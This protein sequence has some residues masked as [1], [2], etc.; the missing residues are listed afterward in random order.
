ML[1]RSMLTISQG[2][3][4]E[5]ILQPTECPTAALSAPRWSPTSTWRSCLSQRSTGSPTQ[6]RS[7]HSCAQCWVRGS[8]SAYVFQLTGGVVSWCSRK[9]QSRAQLNTEIEYVALA[10]AP[11]E[12]L[13]LRTLLDDLDSLLLH[14]LLLR[15]LPLVFLFATS[16]R[17]LLGRIRRFTT[18]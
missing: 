13:W 14:P 12:A 2:Q 9:Q 16:P 4:P 3:Y 1:F 8:T 6:A 17:W 7:V 11:K 18:S 15:F 5:K 10:T